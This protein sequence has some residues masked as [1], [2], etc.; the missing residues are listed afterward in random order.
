M[1]GLDGEGP[2]FDD[3]QPRWGGGLAGLSAAGGGRVDGA[4]LTEPGSYEDFHYASPFDYAAFAAR[5]PGAG[6]PSRPLSPFPPHGNPFSPLP[7]FSPYPSYDSTSTSLNPPLLPAPPSPAPLFDDSEHALFSSFLTNLDVDPNYLFNPVLPPGMPSPPSASMLQQGEYEAERTEREQLGDQVGGLSLGSLGS[8]HLPPLP[9]FEP[10]S[11]QPHSANEETHVGAAEG[12]VP[13]FTADFD[14]EAEDTAKPSPEDDPDFDPGVSRPVRGT[15]RK[16]RSTGSGAAGMNGKKARVQ[17]DEAFADEDVEMLSASIHGLEHDEGEDSVATVTPS[18]RPRRATRAPRRL[19]TSA[20]TSSSSRSKPP[21]RPSLSKPAP[22]P[23]QLRAGPP[24]PSTSF[25]RSHTPAHPAN[26][27]DEDEEEDASLSPAPSASSST[28]TAKHAPLT[29][30][31]KRSNHIASEQRRRN[32]I[33][34]GFQDLVDLLVAGSSASGIVLGGGGGGEEDGDGGSGKKK[35]GKGTGRGRGR[36]GE[37][38]TNA[39]KSVVLA[40]AANYILWLER[41][42]MALKAECERVEGE[43]RAAGLAE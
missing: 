1:S 15:R 13:P 17:E 5:S 18:G 32:A 16:S 30:S 8:G 29:E 23:V 38:A 27:D 10:Q 34:S 7:G 28:A 14:S 22:P 4:F 11:L 24:S 19:S 39:S 12:E 20:T 35:K 40:E 25:G 9:P 6:P 41:G 36:K 43:L 31:E 3:G 37:V 2:D 42:N 26:G 33:K 21:R